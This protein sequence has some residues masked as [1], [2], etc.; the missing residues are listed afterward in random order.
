MEKSSQVIINHNPEAEINA[1]NENKDKIKIVFGDINKNNYEQLRVLNNLALPVKY[2]NGFYLRIVHKLRAGRFAYF[3]DIIV[4]AITWKY[5]KFDNTRS[6][7]I[8]TITVL[9]DYKRHNIG[10]Y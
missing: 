3:N 8:M 7:Y 5:D 2:K 4:G 10:K 9:D 6:I 1:K